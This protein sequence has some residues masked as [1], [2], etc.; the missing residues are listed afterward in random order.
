MGFEVCLL[1]SSIIYVNSLIVL[2]MFDDNN[3]ITLRH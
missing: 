1:R 3:V 2:V